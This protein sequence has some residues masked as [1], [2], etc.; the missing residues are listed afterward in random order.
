MQ[1][2]TADAVLSFL[3]EYRNELISGASVVVM[4]GSMTGLCCLA[5]CLHHRLERRV[6]RTSRRQMSEIMVQG[7]EQ[8]LRMNFLL[9]AIVKPGEFQDDHFRSGWKSLS[10][11]AAVDMDG[12]NPTPSCS[13]F[14]GGSGGRGGKGKK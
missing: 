2:W 3:A 1:G 14:T 6:T 11:Q 9:T 7:D 4:L 5:C 13:S 10:P 12:F 8:K